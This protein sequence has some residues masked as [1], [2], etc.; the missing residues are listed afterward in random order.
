M[1]SAELPP[2][3]ICAERPCVNKWDVVCHRAECRREIERERKLAKLGALDTPE[4]E[5]RASTLRIERS[6]HYV[7]RPDR[8]LLRARG[9]VKRLT[10]YGMDEVSAIGIA[11]DRLGMKRAEVLHAWRSPTTSL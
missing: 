7:E 2:C 9:E 8:L 3:C 4:A 1:A 6:V 10:G 11:A 5:T